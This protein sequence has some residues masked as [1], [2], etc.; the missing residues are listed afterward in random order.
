MS[1]GYSETTGYR[2]RLREALPAFWIKSRQPTPPHHPARLTRNPMERPVRVAILKTGGK[3]TQVPNNIKND[4]ASRKPLPPISSS[5]NKDFPPHQSTFN[6]SI[7]Q[8]TH[9]N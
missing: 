4:P 5:S 3:I 1:L 2:R 8:P 7:N 9:T 6:Q